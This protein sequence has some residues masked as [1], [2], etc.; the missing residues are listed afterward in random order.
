MSVTLRRGVLLMLTVLVPVGAD[1]C[2]LFNPFDTC[3]V[4]APRP[5]IG[6]TVGVPLPT[7][8]C[9]WC[10]P[11]PPPPL[12]GPPL[13]PPTP[14]CF[15]PCGMP[16]A[17]PA[18]VPTS[19]DCAAPP[20]CATLAPQQVTTIR[21]VPTTQV[22]RETYV[23]NVPVTTYQ[24]VTIPRT[25]YQP[26]VRYRDVAYTVNQQI[27]ETRT[28][29]VPQPI[30]SYATPVPALVGCS[31]CDSPANYGPTPG[32]GSGVP[33]T[34]IAPYPH[35]GSA[36]GPVP[37]PI[38]LPS[39]ASSPP[40]TLESPQPYAEAPWQTI[41][42]RQAQQSGEI[43]QMGGFSPGYNLRPASSARPMF[44]PAPSAASVWQSPWRR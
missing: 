19:F 34:A 29:Y 40:A 7:A 1:A 32:Y 38:A 28:Q 33:S 37:T 31:T 36:T 16:P 14:C 4:C 9:G 11:C 26:Q 12:C 41:P 44:Q 25:V 42:Q 6:F 3:G 21:T 30:M 27:A 18:P 23:E 10:G 35:I 17:L 2:C 24:Q 22:R 5:W 43:Q 39:T 20:V 13:P 15:D 8:C